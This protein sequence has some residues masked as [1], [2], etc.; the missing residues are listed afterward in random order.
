[1]SKSAAK[2]LR[3]TTY[4][5]DA[6]NHG[7]SPH[8]SPHDYDSMTNDLMQLLDHEKIDKVSLVGYSM[9]G[10]TALNYTLRY[11]ER[12]EKLIS[13]DIG[14]NS[15]PIGDEFPRYVDA[16]TNIIMK[17]W[18]HVDHRSLQKKLRQQM[19]KTVPN[20][21]MCLYIL[22][23][24]KKVKNHVMSRIPLDLMNDETLHNLGQFPHFDNAVDV[25]ALFIKANG[26]SLLGE[27]GIEE[28]RRLFPRSKLET[29]DANHQDILVQQNSAVNSLILEFLK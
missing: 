9:G 11:P 8:A 10:R 7:S 21:L 17:D 29:L 15:E 22:A 14:P 4:T 19:K 16:L 13:I 23:N 27:Q 25:P 12:V 26:R 28:A 3:R 18:S 2:N 6:R 24:I 5:Y 20:D 1:M